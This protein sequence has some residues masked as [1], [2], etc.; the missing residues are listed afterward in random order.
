MTKRSPSRAAFGT[1]VLALIMITLSVSWAASG[2][3]AGANTKP[4]A[5][6]AAPKSAGA[7]SPETGAALQKKVEN[8]L[9][10]VYAW[11]KDINVKAG[12][13]TAAPVGELYQTTV[14][15]SAEG[16]SDSALVFVSGDGK[17]ILRGELDEMNVDPFAD[18]KSQIQLNGA[19]SKGPAD[20]KVTVVEFGDLEC[21][22]CRQLEP[23]L[24]QVLPQYPQVRFIFKDFPLESVHPWAMQAAVMGHCALEQSSDVFWKYH[25]T[26]YE[27]QDQITP[28]NAS[29]MLP[30]IATAAGADATKLKACTTDPKSTDFVRAS[31][32]NGTDVGV[33]S[34]PTVFV[35]GRKFV[36]PNANALQQYI[37]YDLKP[38]Q[39]PSP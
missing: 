14:V 4:G 20:A 31:L 30:Q 7:L 19:A 24:Q 37:E 17:Y 10:D 29:E 2:Q 39:R 11:G 12:P 3:N 1:I 8:Y 18:V 27:E 15:V 28:Q 13:L 25:D 33:N 32:K 38:N 35:D 6:T 34:T 26:V 21:P 36:G 5:G 23:I 9:R 16:G 22:V